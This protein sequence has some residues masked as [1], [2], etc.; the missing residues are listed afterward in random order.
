MKSSARTEPQRPNGSI[1][2]ES[3]VAGSSRKAAPDELLV[4]FQ[5]CLHLADSQCQCQA[6]E[7]LQSN[8]ISQILCCS[9][10]KDRYPESQQSRCSSDVVAQ[11]HEEL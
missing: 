1:S 4:V 8:F 5:Q 10:S 2:S 11:L 3:Q 9:T 7:T 6:G